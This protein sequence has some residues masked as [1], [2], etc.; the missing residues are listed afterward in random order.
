MTR[1]VT[2]TPR[3]FLRKIWEL[4]SFDISPDGRLLAYSANKG[5]QW[6]VYLRELKTKREK[7]LV[8]SA[9]SALNPEFSPDGQWIA[10]QSDF[11]GDEN[12]N[13]FIVHT[14]GDI[15][16][17]LTD[18]PADSAFP[19]WSPDGTKIAFISNRDRDRENIFVANAE[20]GETKQLTRVD[21]IVNEIAWRPDGKSIVF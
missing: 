3:K 20:G 6:A 4:G 21:D 16:R 15:T 5:E 9:Q 1:T 2:F 17:K 8:E 10:Y 19:S 18:T 12:S 13:I 7:A 11:E 14:R